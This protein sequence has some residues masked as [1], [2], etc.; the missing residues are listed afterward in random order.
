MRS[1]PTHANRTRET[2]ALF[3][4]F[5]AFALPWV[6]ASPADRPH[7]T[8]PAGPNRLLLLLVNQPVYRGARVLCARA[9][10]GKA[11][12][13]PAQ[14]PK[15]QYR[16]APRGG[17]VGV[18]CVRCR[19]PPLT[20]RCA[21]RYATH[22]GGA[23]PEPRHRQRRPCGQHFHEPGG[24]SKRPGLLG[25]HCGSPGENGALRRAAPAQRAGPPDL[26][27]HAAAHVIPLGLVVGW[28]AV[29]TSTMWFP[30]PTDRQPYSIVCQRAVWQRH[31][32]L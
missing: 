12:C 2:L 7:H 22:T 26:Q 4:P 11:R 15:H 24:G 32:R 10:T 18:A 31:L 25:R 3:L 13:R 23:G 28:R 6:S 29:S 21:P 8:P 27:P 1:G 30:P 20:T 16:H 9:A 17:H 14:K 19:G 5:L